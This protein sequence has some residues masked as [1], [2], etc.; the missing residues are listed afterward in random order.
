MTA[1]VPLTGTGV[2]ELVARSVM[3]ADVPVVLAQ[4]SV[5]DCP[6]LTVEGDAEKELIA[7]AGVTATVTVRVSLPALFE[8]VSVYVVVAVGFT[9]S[10][11]EAGGTATGLPGRPGA[12]TVAD[13]PPAALQESVAA[14]PAQTEPTLAVKEE[15]VGG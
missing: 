12:E 2:T 13:V 8:T 3:L 15:M 5:A 9:T 7:G 4:E 14:P 6:A 1:S 10:E 11:P